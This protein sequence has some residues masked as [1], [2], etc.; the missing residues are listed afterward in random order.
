MSNWVVMNFK[1]CEGVVAKAQQIIFNTHLCSGARK[2][3]WKGV[4]IQVSE[5]VIGV[6]T[7]YSSVYCEAGE[8]DFTSFSSYSLGKARVF[9]TIFTVQVQT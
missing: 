8:T 2:M 9:K 4:V 7:I 1:S 3:V 5:L 6:S